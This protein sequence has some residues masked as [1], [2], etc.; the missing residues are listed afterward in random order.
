MTIKTILY[1]RAIELG[2]MGNMRKKFGEV[3]S[4]GFRL[5]E[6]IDRL[7]TDKQI[8]ST[9]YFA[10]SIWGKYRLTAFVRVAPLPN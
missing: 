2:F 1:K 4:C 3:W 9:Q 5:R 8:Y 6:G 7:M 10:P